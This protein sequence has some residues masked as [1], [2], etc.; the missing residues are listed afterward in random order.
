[1]SIFLNQNFILIDKPIGWTSFDAVNFV[2]HQLRQATG[3]KKIKVGHAGTLD[4]FASGLLII[5]VGRENT[6]KIDE[7][8]ALPKTYIA[9]LKL[10]ITSDTFDSTG[11]MTVSAQNNEIKKIT[12]EQIQTVLLS[13]LGQQL[14][15]PPMYSAK[16]IAGRRLYSLARQG[17]T[18]ERQPNE[19]TIF[20]IKLIDY[21]YPNLTIEVQCSTGTY[22][23][24]LAHDIGQKLQVG[25]YCHD[26][27]RTK[28]GP[29]I[30][31]D[32]IKMAD[33]KH[34]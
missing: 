22:I 2:R 23:R 18:I 3:N 1:M 10:G 14:Q 12:R 31:E 5:A 13:F 11:K 15:L 24:T 19:I 16:K 27:R 34:D 17:I 25:A 20:E 29:Y 30:V 6:K 8:K 4:P 21:S 33:L 7:F 32:A 26:L 9:T 28:I